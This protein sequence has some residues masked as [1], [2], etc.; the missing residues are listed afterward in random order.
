MVKLIVISI[1]FLLS[2]CSSLDLK[3]ID[4]NSKILVIAQTND[5]FDLKHIGY[6]FFPRFRERSIEQAQVDWLLSDLFVDFVLSQS[7]ITSFT[8]V[9]ADQRNID[10][11]AGGVISSFDLGVQ[12]LAKSYGADYIL[13]LQTR[14]N[15]DLDGYV[16]DHAQYGFS[17][18][19]DLGLTG[20]YGQGHSFINGRIDL[21]DARNTGENIFGDPVLK[22]NSCYDSMISTPFRDQVDFDLPLD[23]EKGEVLSISNPD[24]LEK[25]YKHS[26][27]TFIKLFQYSLEECLLI[28][29]T[30][31]TKRHARR[32]KD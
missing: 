25:I 30:S 20:Y 14:P 26:K 17:H 8:F 28:P 1:F 2:A 6:N 5:Q 13:A 21:I 7:E 24:E 16:I 12:S 9:T 23:A 3:K 22:E 10:S 15:R 11:S 27:E 4:K 18:F 29:R 32:K 19:I 31:L